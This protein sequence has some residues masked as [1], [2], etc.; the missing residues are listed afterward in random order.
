MA[1]D[2]SIAPPPRRESLVEIVSVHGSSESPGCP[3]EIR[4]AR[5]GSF[6]VDALARGYRLGLIGSGDGHTGHPG[7][8]YGNTLGGLA[9]VYASARTRDAV[10]EALRARRVFATSGARILVYCD[11]D[12][13]PMGGEVAPP[14]HGGA[15]VTFRVRAVGSEAIERIDLVRDGRV[16][17][18]KT[19]GA[20]ADSLVFVDNGPARPGSWTFARVVQVDGETAWSSPI[21][22]AAPAAAPR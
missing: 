5:P 15:G 7:K 11:A 17:A 14:A 4:D 21:W 18:Q 16:L 1:T 3:S 20:T 6:V 9:G 8:P 13:V 10:W 22:F 19:S 12:G 2:W